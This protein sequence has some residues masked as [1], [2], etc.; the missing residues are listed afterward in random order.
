MERE[1]RDWAGHYCTAALPRTD[2]RGTNTTGN[3]YIQYSTTRKEGEKRWIN[4]EGK[5][6][7]RTLVTK[8]EYEHFIKNTIEK[9]HTNFIFLYKNLQNLDC[10][11]DVQ[12][13]KY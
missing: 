3:M 4:G 6:H 2:Y 11:Y 8:K 7:V 13:K 12:K 10:S 1:V 5:K 9:F